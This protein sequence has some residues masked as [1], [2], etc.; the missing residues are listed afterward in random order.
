MCLN[1]MLMHL[2]GYVCLDSIY[3]SVDIKNSTMKSESF[4]NLEIIFVVFDN[5]D[6]FILLFYYMFSCVHSSS[7]SNVP[8]DILFH[9]N[10]HGDIHCMV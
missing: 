2:L 10:K 8:F 4:Q 1:L 7:S 6:I 3:I 5:I 9:S